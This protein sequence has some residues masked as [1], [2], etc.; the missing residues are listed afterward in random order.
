MITGRIIA[1]V[2]AH[3]APR[4]IEW[5]FASIV[6]LLGF[7]LLQP[8]NTFASAPATYRILSSLAPEAVWGWFLFIVGG[9]RLVALTLNG[10]WPPFAPYSPLMRAIS[11]F[12]TAGIWM[13]LS[14]G[15]YFGN[16]AGTGGVTYFIMFVFDAFVA[17]EIG[18]EAGRAL[19]ER[20]HGR[21]P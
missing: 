9:A 20:R 21:V 13:A 2:L 3:F 14:F 16:S 18:V 7:K 6:F 1:D 19:R 12:F 5:L 17:T 15:I 4:R 10:T 8:E 11:G